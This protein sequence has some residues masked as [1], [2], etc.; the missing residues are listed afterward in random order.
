MAKYFF[1][2]KVLAEDYVYCLHAYMYIVSS[3]FV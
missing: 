3:A 2:A 1:I